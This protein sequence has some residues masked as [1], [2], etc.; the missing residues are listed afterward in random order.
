MANYHVCDICGRMM[1][2]DEKQH[3]FIHIGAKKTFRD[4]NPDY[5][6][7]P[8]VNIEVCPQCAKDTAYD[9]KRTKTAHLPIIPKSYEPEPIKS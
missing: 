8:Y 2:K 6:G 3:C 7:I 1:P 5:D 4:I 9:I